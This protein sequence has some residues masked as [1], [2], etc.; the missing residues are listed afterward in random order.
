VI[1]SVIAALYRKF[2]SLS[3]MDE[4]LSAL[5]PVVVAL[6]AAAGLKVLIG[7]IFREG[8]LSLSAMDIPAAVCY[9]P[10]WLLKAL[11]HRQRARKFNDLRVARRGA[12]VGFTPP[13][14]LALGF[15]ICRHDR[16]TGRSLDG[17]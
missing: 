2:R 14:R 9:N 17:M 5:R 10:P 8:A 1:V 3:A 16:A 11:C 4:I 12:M 6:I 15:L 7:A 13:L